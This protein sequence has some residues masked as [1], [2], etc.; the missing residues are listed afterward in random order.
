MY[1]PKNGLGKPQTENLSIIWH[2]KLEKLCIINSLLILSSPKPTLR[3]ISL[4]R[5]RASLLFKN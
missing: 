3:G 1:L 5:K 4:K 2:K